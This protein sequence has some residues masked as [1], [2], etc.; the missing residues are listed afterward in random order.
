MRFACFH[1]SGSQKTHLPG[2]ILVSDGHPLGVFKCAFGR[3]PALLE[4]GSL[5]FC[6]ISSYVHSLLKSGL[7]AWHANDVSMSRVHA[8]ANAHTMLQA[9][10]HRIQIPQPPSNNRFPKLAIKLKDAALKA[11][12]SCLLPFGTTLSFIGHGRIGVEILFVCGLL[13]LETCFTTPETMLMDRMMSSPVMI[14]T[15]QLQT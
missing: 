2:S 15:M 4:D 9:G 13:A 7:P 5:I 8:T 12:P 11:F 6:W 10:T 1:P 14:H 3:P